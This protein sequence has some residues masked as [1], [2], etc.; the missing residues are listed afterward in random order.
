MH[1]YIFKFASQG[2]TVHGQFIRARQ[3]IT[4]H[5]RNFIQ[6]DNKEFDS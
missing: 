1:E 6:W 4:C 2:K 5:Y 3:N